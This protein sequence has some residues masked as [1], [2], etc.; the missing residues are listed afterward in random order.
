MEPPAF[1]PPPN[2]DSPNSV[3]QCL[4]PSMRGWAHDPTDK[5]KWLK[6]IGAGPAPEPGEYTIMTDYEKY[7]PKGVTRRHFLE[8]KEHTVNLD[9][10]EFK[11]AKLYNGLFPGPW[12][13]ACWGDDI[14]ITVRNKLQYNGTAVHWH[15]LRMLG[16]NLHDGV[17]G[18]TQ[19]PIAPAD[20][21]TYKFKAI[22]YGSSWYHSH[23]SLQYTDGLVGPLTIHGPSSANYDQSIDP[24]LMQDH[25]HTSAFQ[26]YT[27]AQNGRPPSMHSILLNGIG[28]YTGLGAQAPTRK[29]STVVTKGKKYLLRLI[30]TSTDAIF[31]FSID[32][33]NFTVVG[34][35]FVPMT[36][37]QTDHLVVGIGQRYH[38][39]L[40]TLPNATNG[41]AYWIR[42]T[43]T[44]GCS[45]FE[46]NNPPDEKVGILYY[47]RRTT[48][49]PT[50]TGQGFPAACR[51]EPFERLKPY[52]PWQVP[53][54]QV[55]PTPLSA[56]NDIGLGKWRMPGRPGT[57]P[58]VNFWAIGPS[59]MYLNYSQPMVKSLDRSTWDDTWVV[60][61]SEEHTSNDWVYLLITGLKSLTA[62]VGVQ[63]PAAH[64][65]HL[66]GHDFALLQQSSEA[67]KPSLL[68]LKLDNPPR[69]DVTLL[70]AG[71]FIVI[72]FKADNP[73]SWV[74][75]CHIAW[76]ASMGLALQILERKNDFKALLRTQPNDVAEMNRV[77]RNWDSW[78]GNPAN[79]WN[80]NDFFQEDS[81]I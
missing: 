30:N 20:T 44:T 2:T 32:N 10:V 19:C 81:G 1:F 28:S 62:K 51:D 66:H 6:W 76:H 24:L 47:E 61:P 71:G 77:C 15:G 34:A 9:G 18:I 63:I 43:P 4:Y 72:A 64:P 38:V 39:I 80:S 16:T 5:R 65:I 56:S 22:Q 74:M 70:P 11:R 12:I 26:A 37:Y 27:I 42:L 13:Q 33:H 3:I 46:A 35:D 41:S 78:Y 17:P 31:V 14:E 29:Y 58:E 49:M 60:Y 69:R 8:V 79:H 25:L 59:P 45:V 48:T 21:F 7:T 50:S 57:G 67:F 23:Y 52:H 55:A 54:P 73:G 53:D 36:P 68:N 40:D 75:H